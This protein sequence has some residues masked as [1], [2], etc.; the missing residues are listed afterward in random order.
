MGPNRAWHPVYPVHP[1]RQF[2]PFEPSK[3]NNDRMNRMDGPV[4]SG[5]RPQCAGPGPTGSVVVLGAVMA[6]PIRLF[7]QPARAKAGDNKQVPTRAA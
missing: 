2:R 6:S 3:P 5:R 4:S 7:H 1:V